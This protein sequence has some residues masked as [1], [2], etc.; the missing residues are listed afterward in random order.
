ISERVMIRPLDVSNEKERK[1]LIQEV[2]N[3]WHGVNV[4]INN[5][6]I[7]FRSVVEHMNEQDE[8]LQMAANYFG[9]MGMIREVLPHMRMLGRGKIIC[10]SS[11]SG[12]LAMPTMA[13]YSAS[14]HA[15]EG[16]CEALW[17]E[18]K[19]LGIDVCLVQPGFINSN[20][21]KN[22]YVSQRAKEALSKNDAYSDYYRH[23]SPFIEK[24]MTRSRATPGRVARLIL[25]VIKT[26]NPPL[27][28]PATLDA[29][30]FY[31]IRRLLPRR[32]LLP[33]LFMCLPNTK[34]WANEY[35]HKR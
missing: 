6:G 24:M 12:M 35:T 13:S 30:I 8:Q 15:L 16:A 7:S 18:G 11:V 20:S 3:K 17:Y 4:L 10:I 25:D 29:T 2:E 23:M 21:F 32:L 33:V 34:K 27:W 22:V 9:P 1:A 19:P 5:A 26:E 31:F 14:K 28:I